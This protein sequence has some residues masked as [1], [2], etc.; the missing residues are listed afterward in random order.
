MLHE[1]EKDD[2]QSGASLSKDTPL[3][4]SKE[5]TVPKEGRSSLA[6]PDANGVSVRASY[7]VALRHLLGGETNQDLGEIRPIQGVRTT[8]E[9]GKVAS[10]AV[11]Y[12]GVVVEALA[13]LFSEYNRQFQPLV[14]AN[15]E[16]ATDYRYAKDSD[17]QFVNAF[18]QIDMLGLPPQF[19]KRA[20]G[21]DRGV[22][23]EVLRHSIFE[24]EN[25]LAMYQLLEKA[26]SATS[27]P[28]LFSMRFR[29]GLDDLRRQ[30]RRPIMLL[31]V[32]A[33]KFEA[34][35][36]SEF[37]KAPG[38]SLSHDEV[39]EMSGFDGLLGPD[40]FKQHLAANGGRCEY[41]LYVRSSDPP[42]KLRYPR[43]QVGSEL[44]EDSQLRRI[45]KENSLT[46]NID[47][48]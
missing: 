41:L 10:H 9:L 36:A 44:L 38:E 19:L 45:I 42:S 39:R 31:A 37:G 16:F 34:M 40:Q 17:G 30:H 20:A 26:L 18:V 35:R 7:E 13:E 4:Q 25:S 28:S 14:Q 23:K 47:A 27:G 15:R 21:L 29:R 46:F 32:T 3:E 22:V 8:L 24:I 6:S 33:E 5:T 12:P 43:A 1:S 11:Q 2:P 48:P